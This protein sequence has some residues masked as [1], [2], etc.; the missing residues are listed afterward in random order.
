[1]ITLVGNGVACKH[2][3]AQAPLPLVPLNLSRSSHSA[4]YRVFFLQV[5]TQAGNVGT[6]EGSFGKSGKFR[7]SFQTA[8]IPPK[9][10]ANGITLTFKRF[11]HDANKKA[12]RQ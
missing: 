1:M 11:I 3:L 7:V 2:S 12:L 10:G 4:K 9:P 8:I 5:T 6:I